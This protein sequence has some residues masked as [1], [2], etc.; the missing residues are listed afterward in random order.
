MTTRTRDVLRKVD[1]YLEE[2]IRDNL[3]EDTP[4][5]SDLA[6]EVYE[7]LHSTHTDATGGLPAIPPLTDKKICLAKFT[8]S[9]TD[10]YCHR[11][12]GLDT[13]SPCYHREAWNV[14]EREVLGKMEGGAE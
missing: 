3:V 7:V 10:K 9:V 8:P 5:A 6:D 1:D 2:L 14:D 12:D 11:C 13:T 4:R